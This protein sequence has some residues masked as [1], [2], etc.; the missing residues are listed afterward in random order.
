M[1]ASSKRKR[2]ELDM[3]TRFD[4]IQCSKANPQESKRKLAEKFNCGRTQIQ[5]ILK[6][7]DEILKNFE[8]NC[9]SNIKR[10]RGA[11]HEEVDNVLLEWFQN[12]RTKTCQLLVPCYKKLSNAD[13]KSFRCAARGI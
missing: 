11:K 2:E 1:S 5:T 4:V 8:G 6:K 9:S 3:K 7:K 10:T 12:T 13:S